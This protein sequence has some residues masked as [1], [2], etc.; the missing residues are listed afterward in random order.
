MSVPVAVA[1]EFVL[2]SLI[3]LAESS[4]RIRAVQAAG[5]DKLNLAEWQAILE[6]NDQARS[7]AQA[8]VDNA[9]IEGR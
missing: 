7:D 6:G 3:K 5:R 9:I 8:A 2:N 1:T 4:A